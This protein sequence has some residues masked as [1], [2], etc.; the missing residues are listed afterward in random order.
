M[1]RKQKEVSDEVKI[2]IIKHLRS[3]LTEKKI[4]EIVNRPRSTVQYIIKKWKETKSV[5]NKQRSGRPKALSIADNRWLV[6]Q[7]Q[8]NPKTNATILC[9]NAKEY[10]GKEITPQTIRN[11]LKIHG[12]R[13]RTA[14]KKP[15]VNK[16]NRSKR[17]KFAR[18]YV[19]E[20]ES[21]WTNVIFA[22]ESKF[23]LFGCDG[24]V[25]V[26]R[27]A[28]TE[29]E[30]RNTVATVKHGGG[31]LMVWGCMAASGAGNIEIIN[32]TMD[33]R[34]YIEILKRNLKD[35]AQKLGIGDNFQYY[36][37]NDPKHSALNTKLWMLYNCPKVIK[38]PPQSPDLNPIEHLWE[39]LE[40]KL[41]KRSFSN[42]TQMQ[43][44][45]MEEWANIDTAITT[46]LVQSMQ[47]RLKE[48][49]RRGGRITKY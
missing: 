37:D 43:L 40:L 10:L 7:I 20:P 4:G 9:N 11:S 46:K 44:I 3:G 28:N 17:L 26:Y 12:Y 15:F 2:L 25:I 22:D 29:L 5:E 19:K 47:R 8:K 24:K 49:I 34:Y 48:V 42:K 6:R 21:F 36:Q 30:E 27:K 13:G 33:H 32:G 18:A 41:R 31:G 14:R 45:L 16:I 35:S 23:N 38:T 39:H 1:G